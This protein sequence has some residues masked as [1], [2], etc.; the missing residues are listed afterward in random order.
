VDNADNTNGKYV[1]VSYYYFSAS[2]SK[3]I[4]SV[5]IINTTTNSIVGNIPIGPANDGATGMSITPNGKSV[6]LVGY[7]NTNM[8]MINTSTNTAINMTVVNGHE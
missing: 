5:A 4:I 1:Y 6:Y 3:G 2:E 8:A 7:V